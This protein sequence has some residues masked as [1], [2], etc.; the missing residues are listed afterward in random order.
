[1][2]WWY[3]AGL[4]FPSLLPINTFSRSA[5]PMSVNTFHTCSAF[6]SPSL[7]ECFV[8]VQPPHSEELHVEV[9]YSAN[10]G[11]LLSHAAWWTTFFKVWGLVVL[12]FLQLLFQTNK[13][14][15]VKC[16]RDALEY[17]VQIICASKYHV[18]RLLYLEQVVFK[19]YIFISFLGEV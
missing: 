9:A 11:Y 14:L 13:A 8:L 17:S 12:A 7:F 2:G 19:W 10:V 6:F 18:S 3:P 5:F 1:M 4:V 16:K 15:G